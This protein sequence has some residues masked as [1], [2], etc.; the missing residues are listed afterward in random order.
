MSAAARIAVY[1]TRRLRFAP[2]TW[3]VALGLLCLMIV[4][5]FPSI[6]GSAGLDELVQSYPEAFKQAFGVTDASFSTIEGYLSVEVFS[7]IA[8]L[9][10]AYFVIH[11]LARAVCGSEQRGVLDVLL[12]APLRRRQLLI[13]WL[14]GAAAALLGVLTVMAVICQASALAFGVDLAAAD[15]AAA[16]LSL[17][18]L[19]MFFGGLT[20]LLAGLSGRSLVVTGVAFGTLVAMYFVEVLGKLSASVAAVDGLSAFHYYGSAI[21]DGI[22][23]AGVAGLVA[24]GLLLAAAG[25]ALFERRDVRA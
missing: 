5:V 4:A 8:P 22:D 6:E 20:L 25:C 23:P 9:A 11:A 2:L 7:L 19:S 13:G 17:W 15:T 14:A 18:P 21:E 16:A 1:A 3:G 24:A 12:S 10:C